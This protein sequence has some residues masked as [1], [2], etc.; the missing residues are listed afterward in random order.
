MPGVGQPA[1]GVGPATRR[2][3]GG[4]FGWELHEAFQQLRLRRRRRGPAPRWWRWPRLDGLSS[5]GG[6]GRD[7]VELEESSRLWKTE[8]FKSCK[9]FIPLGIEIVHEVLTTKD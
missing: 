7:L 2:R 1:P 5:V 6:G 3:G 8:I 9:V 4:L